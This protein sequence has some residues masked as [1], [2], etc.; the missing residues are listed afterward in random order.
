MLIISPND[1]KFS[2]QGLCSICGHYGEFI[3]GDIESTRESFPCQNCRS[4]LRYRDQAAVIIDQFSNGESRC[5]KGLVESGSL[6]HLSIYEVALK[7]PFASYFEVLPGYVRSYLWDD[8]KSGIA[9]ENGVLCEDLTMLTFKNNTFDLI[10]TSDVMEHISD[11]ES[12]FSE[13]LRVLRVGGVHI[14]SIP[15]EPLIAPFS[16]RRALKIGTKEVYFKTPRYHNS[17]N[18]S[19]CLTY[20]DFGSD[21]PKLIDKGNS[22]TKIL[23]RT[24]TG[25]CHENATFITFKRHYLPI[26]QAEGY[27]AIPSFKQIDHICP[28]CGGNMF[29]EFNGRKNARC[30]KCLCMER[31]RL[32]SM[33]LDK[34][35]L[36]QS[37]KKVLH[38]A[39]EFGL[40][41]R[42]IDS[43][44]EFYYPCDFE[45][46]KYK[47]RFYQ[48][49]FIDLSQE[50][51][52]FEDN[53]FDL[54]IH[55][56]VLEHV[57]SDVEATLRELD[58]ILKP[59]GAHF[60]SIPISGEWT[61]E[62]LSKEVSD[63]YRKKNFGQHDH[64]RIFGWKSVKNLL[65]PI[66]K[67]HDGLPL[68]PLKYFTVHELEKAYIPRIAWDGVCGHSIYFYTKPVVI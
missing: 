62:N 67:N 60:F 6:N 57:P 61:R 63:S 34:F 1:P 5:L 46:E 37:G 3:R 66:W 53:S 35:D 21:L 14:F 22:E 49:Q 48:T 25:N 40:A 17:G 32:L 50:L 47:S 42:L 68:R 10:I 54:I 15:T 19:D 33:F 65:M 59:G 16:E 11:Y 29:L 30:K 28:I 2:Y 24:M 26:S 44:G 12:A 36:Y 4:T 38:L 52:Q 45:P 55:N 58:R 8:C 9:Y 64:V 56:H 43:C 18:G 7:S 51:T 27:Q 31:N 20:T 13:I 41:K 39:P 23:R